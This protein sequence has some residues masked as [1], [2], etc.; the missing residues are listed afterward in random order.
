MHPPLHLVEEGELMKTFAKES[1]AL[2][3]GYQ[4]IYHPN[5]ICFNQQGLKTA[6]LYQNEGMKI[7]QITERQ[8][9]NKIFSMGEKEIWKSFSEY[10]LIYAFLHSIDSINAIH[11]DGENT[12]SKEVN[13]LSSWTTVQNSQA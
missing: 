4:F 13:N 3:I 9:K 12:I 6:H 10:T 7:I 8:N 1:K 2:L 5:N 11:V